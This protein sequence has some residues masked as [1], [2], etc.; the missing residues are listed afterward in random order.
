MKRQCV[1]IIPN[2]IEMDCKPYEKMGTEGHPKLTEP[3]FDENNIEHD[4]KTNLN[5]ELVKLGC[6]VVNA[7][8]SPEFRQNII[9]IP[10]Y[11]TERQFILL[12]SYAPFFNE[13]GGVHFGIVTDDEI[14]D[15]E[16]KEEENPNWLNT[17]YREVRSKCLESKVTR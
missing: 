9:F 2:E 8:V 5:M 14:I 4:E 17:F 10:E 7:F 15:S 11:I 3:F 1:I 12:K 6:V 13:F 16:L